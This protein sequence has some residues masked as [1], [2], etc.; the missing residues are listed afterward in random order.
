MARLK[1]NKPQQ[2]CGTSQPCREYKPLIV[3]EGQYVADI[4]LRDPLHISFFR[5][6]AAKA[7]ISSC[8]M[9]DALDQKGVVA[10]FSGADVKHLGKL[11]VNP[12]LGDVKHMDFPVLASQELLHVGQPVA[13]VLAESQAEAVDAVE[14]IELDFEEADTQ[15]QQFS[16]FVAQWSKGNVEKLFMQADHI[17]E[18]EIQHSR[19][20]PSPMENRGIAV[21]FNP[22]EKSV[23]LWISSQTPH[24]AK[25]DLSCILGVEE[26]L[27]RVISPDV[28]GAFGLK[29]SLYPEEVFAVWA[30]FKLRRSVRWNS[31]RSEDFLAA[32]HGRGAQTSGRMAVSS[33]GKFL[34]LEAKVVAPVGSWLTNSSAIPAWNAARILPGAYNIEAYKLKTKGLRTDTAPVGIYRGAGRPEAAMLMEQLVDAAAAVLSIDPI[35]IR[36]K[37]LLSPD[38]LPH[39]RNTGATLDSGD[40]PAALEKLLKISNYPTLQK[41]QR[42]RQK[43]GE[44]VGIGVGMFVEPCGSGWESA[45]VVMNEDGTIVV[46]SGSSTQGHARKPPMHKLLLIYL[47][48]PWKI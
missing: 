46:K 15:N 36:R 1:S 13:A 44:L 39:R 22:K 10:V 31:S 48:V 40:Y 9:N 7:V 38:K 29:A 11:S 12:V 41:K 30:A 16:P 20:A 32:S 26:N 17:V 19:L 34:A 4:V 23:T 24:R 33:E 21:N 42:K 5:S 28:G 37:N 25:S 3:G 2:F 35:E 27:I 8:E 14:I 43:R 6:P 18:V 45:T 47:V